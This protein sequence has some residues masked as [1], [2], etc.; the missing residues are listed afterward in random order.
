MPPRAPSRLA[1]PFS[2]LPPPP[3][4]KPGATARTRL[5]RD[6]L[7]K[8]APGPRSCQ[9][10]AGRERGERVCV[11]RCGCLSLLAE[12]T[13]NK[14]LA[15]RNI[16]RQT[17]GEQRREGGAHLSPGESKGRCRL[18][19]HPPQRRPPATSKHAWLRLCV[20]CTHK[21]TKAV[22]QIYEVYLSPTRCQTPTPIIP[23]GLE[24]NQTAAAEI[25]RCLGGILL[26]VDVKCFSAK[27]I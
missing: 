10:R 17:D 5:T 14:K 6:G 24:R 21:H 16:T 13:K 26:G 12:T 3:G 7:A 4:H 18:I 27:Q 22:S 11:G 2:F 20:P 9:V 25:A 23:A 19:I 1:G 8:T 15:W